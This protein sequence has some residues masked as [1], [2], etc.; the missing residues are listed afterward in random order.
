MMIPPSSC[1][2]SL[3]LRKSSTLLLLPG[4]VADS[5]PYGYGL[6]VASLDASSGAHKHAQTRL[7][8]DAHVVVVGVSHGPAGRVFASL[9]A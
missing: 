3:T 4:L 5:W 9:L 6:T 7:L 1:R 2:P 8:Q